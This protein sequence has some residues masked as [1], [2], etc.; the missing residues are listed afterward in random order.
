MFTIDTWKFLAGLGLFLYGI[1]LMDQ[2]ARRMAGRS[3]KLFL[4]HSTKSLPKA[5]LGGTLITGLVQSSSVVIF[6]LMSFVGAGVISFRNALGVLIGSNLGTTVDSWFIATVGFTFNLQAY[7]L[8]MI[9][10]AGIIMFFSEKRKQ[11]YDSLYFIFCIGILL[12]GFGF[13]KEG[14][15]QLVVTFNLAG[16][17]DYNLFLVLLAGFVITVLI[18]SSS[19]TVAIALTALHTQV[20][21]FPAAACLILGSETGT[22]IKILL[23]SLKGS[24]EKMMLAFGDFIFNVFT[25]VL[26]FTLLPWVII[27]IRQSIGIKDSMIGLVFFQSFIN[28]VSILLIYPFMKPF[29]DWLEKVFSKR[30]Q[31]VEGRFNYEIP[32]MPELAPVLLQKATYDVLAM[33]LDFHKKIFGV[34]GNPATA[35]FLPQVKAFARIHGTTDIEYTIIKE[36][37]GDILQYYNRLQKKNLTKRQYVMVNKYLS[38]T[39]QAIHAAKSIHDIR[40]DLKLFQSSANNF[41]YDQSGVLKNDWIE[42]DGLYDSLL[43]APAEKGSELAINKLQAASVE[44]YQ[45]DVKKI[46]DATS[47]LGLGKVELSTLLNVYQELLSS[48]K[49]L[50]AA[51]AILQSLSP[52]QNA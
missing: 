49:A 29:A 18:Q 28:L 1:S 20:L 47:P 38:A 31:V 5:I 34:T 35:G 41:L 46:N 21:T 48:K 9:G 16:L 24:P 36:T 44:K 14:A 7:S 32:A 8:P 13:M 23:G 4:R 45:N 22:T 3:F 11:L 50:L 6:M 15:E 12:L 43:T 40:H 52:G 25:T 37:E 10:I 30:K 27:F 33:V 39:R 2:L 17:A 51:A 19:A 42:F 26:F